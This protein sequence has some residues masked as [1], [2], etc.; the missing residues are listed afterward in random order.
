MFRTI[1]PIFSILAALGIFFFYVQPIYGDIRA[2]QDETAEYREAVERANE[3]NNL[4]ANLIAQRNAFSANEMERLE[5]FVPD[6]IDVVS[7]LVDVEAIAAEN[8]MS[9]GEIDVSDE[10][11][12][13]APE[14]DAQSTT[15]SNI[16]YGDFITKEV[17]FQL[18]GTYDQMRDTLADLEQSLVLM[19]IVGFGFDVSEGDLLQFEMTVRLYALTPSV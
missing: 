7:M 9:M 4:L 14:E 10:A 18:I 3:F 2:V 16:S 17:S 13:A 15:A 5:A 8:G 19:D 11:S 12:L 1:T 6:T